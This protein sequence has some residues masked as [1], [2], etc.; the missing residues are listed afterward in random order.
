M[1]PLTFKTAKA[2]AKQLAWRENLGYQSGVLAAVL[3]KW[4]DTQCTPSTCAQAPCFIVRFLSLTDTICRKRP[5]TTRIKIAEA[6][7]VSIG[8]CLPK[9]CDLAT[10]HIDFKVPLTDLFLWKLPTEGP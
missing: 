1:V 8:L 9:L 7:L 3:A 2:L 5:R 10:R 4:P 6:I